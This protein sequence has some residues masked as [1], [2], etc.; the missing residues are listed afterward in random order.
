MD[1]R[2]SVSHLMGLSIGLLEWPYNMIVCLPQRKW[3]Q[4]T[5][6]S[7]QHLLR[8]T[9]RSHTQNFCSILLVIDM[10]W[11]LRSLQNSYIEVLIPNVMALDGRTSGREFGF[12]Q[13]VTWS[14]LNGTDTL[15]K[16]GRDQSPLS[17]SLPRRRQ[18]EDA[19]CKLGQNSHQ[20]PNLPEPLGLQNCEKRMFTIWAIEAVGFH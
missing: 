17:P 20:T 19:I 10:D 13:D 3:P 1:D 2:F 4:N 11:R 15:I 16:R 14:P 7:P 5:E 12:D 18:K 9:V 6:W 8:P